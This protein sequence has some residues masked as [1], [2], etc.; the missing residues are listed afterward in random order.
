MRRYRFTVNLLALLAP[1][2][3]TTVTLSMPNLA[4]AG[5]LHLTRVA[6]QER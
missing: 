2:A 4:L 6:L 5:T 3:V 1:A